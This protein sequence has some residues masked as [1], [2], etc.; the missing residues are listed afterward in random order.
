MRSVFWGA[1]VATAFLLAPLAPAQ[2]PPVATPLAWQVRFEPATLVNG[3][4][5]VLY[6]VPPVQL[7]ALSGSLMGHQLHFSFDAANRLLRIP[8]APGATG[9]IWRR[10]ATF[11]FD[12][13]VSN[14]G[15]TV[16]PVR[17]TA[18]VQVLSGSSLRGRR[19]IS[20]SA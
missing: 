16:P 11:Q 5:A 7:E 20:Q 3:A 6:V 13:R 8:P 10:R 9:R 2:N 4:P 17:Q 15:D 18:C 14:W 19:A 12:T 1:L